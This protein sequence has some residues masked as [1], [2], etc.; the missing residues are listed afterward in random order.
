MEEMA[1]LIEERNTLLREIEDAEKK[2]KEINLQRLN[3]GSFIKELSYRESNL[4]R[5]Y[6][7]IGLTYE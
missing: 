4:R 7:A 6:E 5:K 2:L 1:T 3:S